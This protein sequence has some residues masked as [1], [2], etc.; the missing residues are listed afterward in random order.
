MDVVTII[1]PYVGVSFKGTEINFGMSQKE[2]EDI[3]G[4]PVKYEVN[5]LIDLIWEPRDCATFFYGKSGLQS[6]DF[7]LQETQKVS[8]EDIDI[9]H[10]KEAVIKL[11]KF[12]MPTADDGKYMNFYKLGICLGGFGKKRIPEKKLVTVF[13]ENQMAQMVVRYRS[14]GGKISHSVEDMKAALGKTGDTEHSSR[15]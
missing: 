5:N 14:G 7:P 15:F 6:V 9:L 3:L 10:D 8:Y 13:P 1:K 12:D 2:V 4:K 11:S